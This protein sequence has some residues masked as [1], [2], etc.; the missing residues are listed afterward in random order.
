MSIQYRPKLQL[1]IFA[2][3][4]AIEISLLHFLNTKLKTGKRIFFFVKMQVLKID[5]R[6]WSNIRMLY[7][8]PSS[9]AKHRPEHHNIRHAVHNLKLR[10]YNQKF[11]EVVDS[12][13][14]KK[15]RFYVACFFRISHWRTL[16]MCDFL[17]LISTATTAKTLHFL[18]KT[19]NSWK[20][21]SW[22]FSVQCLNLLITQKL[23]LLVKRKKIFWIFSH[24]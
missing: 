4:E 20:P 12:G 1:K 22:N 14:R 21:V 19:S 8:T 16:I 2:F 11:K 17:F 23:I 3:A 5:H 9:F 10:L 15:W 24:H 7:P 18:L 6:H 13:G